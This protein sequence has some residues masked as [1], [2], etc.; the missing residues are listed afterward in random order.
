MLAGFPF[1]SSVEIG[2]EAHPTFL[3]STYLSWPGRKSP[4]PRLRIRGDIPPLIYFYGLVLGDNL[5][6]LSLL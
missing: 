2:S 5:P 3:S 1:F 6:F 4:V